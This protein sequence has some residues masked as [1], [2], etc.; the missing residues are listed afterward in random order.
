MKNEGVCDGCKYHN[1][2][3]T[4]TSAGYGCSYLEKEGSSR[5]VIEMKNGGYKQNSCIC[6]TSGNRRKYRPKPIKTSI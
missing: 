4:E 5:L 1:T 6:Y 2:Y 3:N